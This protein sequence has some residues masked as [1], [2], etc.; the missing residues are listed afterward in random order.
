MA[1]DWETRAAEKRQRLSDDNDVLELGFCKRSGIPSEKELDITESHNVSEL[2]EALAGGKLTALEVTTAFC[3]RAA[4]AHQLLTCC[5]EIFFDKAL[6][7]AKELDA[8]RE[9][10]EPLGPFHGLPISVKD[11]IQVAGVPATLGLV[12]FLDDDVSEKNSAVVDIILASGAIIYC[13]TNVP[14]TMMTVDSHNNVFGR[15]LNPLNTSLSA[16]GSSGGEGAIIGFRGSPLGLGT[17]VGGSV[18]F[19]AACNGI[20][21]FRPTVGRIPSGDM[22]ICVDPGMRR[23]G[24]A[25]NQ[26]VVVDYRPW[27]LDSTAIDL[28]WRDVKLEAGQKLRI[29]VMAQDP[30]FPLHP[31]IRDSVKEAAEKLTAAGH[32]VIPLQPSDGLLWEALQT[33]FGLFSLDST[34][35]RIV[36]E[37]G[38]PPIPSREKLLKVMAFAPWTY[39]EN[40]EKLEG[41][42][43]LSALNRKRAEIARV[44]HAA[45]TKYNLDA[46][47]G[48]LMQHT[49]APHDEFSGSAYGT[50]FNLID[51]PACVIPFG[52]ATAKDGE[53]FELKPGQ[54]ASE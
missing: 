18:R 12:A 8:R 46:V 33:A 25:S 4:I 26:V 3:K 47:I 21:G 45:Y 5:T 32:R 49:A 48:P 10:G 27:K 9:R 39:L 23:S 38:E 29:G 35:A 43:R 42:A 34:G 20:Y 41:L 51:Y 19:P 2:L 40:V 17:D 52:R 44:W 22:K 30:A 15:T 16:G 13:K 54:Y 1:A 7:R 11:N 14:Q 6:Q 31:P 53:T 36:E 24:H 50:I 28:P 37:A